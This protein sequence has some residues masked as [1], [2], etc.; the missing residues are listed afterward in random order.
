MTKTVFSKPFTQQEPVPDDAIDRVVE[1]LKS[2]RLHRY[3]TLGD[4]ASEA[5]LLERDYA[6]YQGSKYCV[7]CTSGGYA[8]TVALRSTGLKPGD[9]ILANAYTLAPVPGAIYA[10]GGVPVFVEIDDDWHTDLADL[11]KKAVESGA[12]F[13]MLSHMR[14]HIAGYGCGGCNLRET[15]HHPD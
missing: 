9:K 11:E 8:L 1:I 5:S 6:T 12:R 13:M 3:N 2:G 10:A 7:A 14:G 15:Q 4:E